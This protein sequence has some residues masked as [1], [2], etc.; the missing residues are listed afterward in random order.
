LR[1]QDRLR[2]RTSTP[3]RPQ[4][5]IAYKRFTI[6]GDKNPNVR[7]GRLCGVA[8]LAQG[9]GVRDT[10]QAAA[11]GR[12]RALVFLRGGPLEQFGDPATV[13][14][15]LRQAE[16]V[17]VM[18]LLP[19]AVSERAHWVLP[20]VSFAE[21]DGT[22]TNSKGRVQRIRKILTIRGDTREDW[23]ILQDL[24]RALGVLAAADPDPERIFLRLAQSVPAFAGLSGPGRWVHRLKPR[25]PT[26]PWGDAR[27]RRSLLHALPKTD[28]HVHLDGSIRPS[29]LFELAREQRVK[30][31][32][33]D[34][35]GLRRFLSRLTSGVSLPTYLKAFDLTLSVLQEAAALERAAFELAEDAHLENVRYMEVRYCPALHTKRGLTLPDI[36]D[37]VVRGLSQAERRYGIRTGTIICGI[38]HLTPKLS[39]TLAELAVA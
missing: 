14:R 13:E 39:L 22:F 8:P 35:A 28:L 6:E 5:E 33:R 26:S 3:G 27:R 20:G 9:M 29:T 19:S 7:G 16:L 12:I 34:P 17:V 11:D 18:D 23:R 32:V 38:R 4:P 1:L 25:R 15:A 21:K 2:I 36:V 24:G 10:I 37:A 30:L 31:L